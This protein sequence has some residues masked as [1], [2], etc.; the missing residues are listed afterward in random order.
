MLYG[1]ISDSSWWGDEVTPKQFA[2]DLANLGNKEQINVRINSGGG[3]V[4]AANAIATSLKMHGANVVIQIDGICASA[5]T[6]IAMAGNKIVIPSYAQMMIH[7]PKTMLFDYMEAKDMIKMADTLETIKE[8]IINA[9]AD[10]TGK[11]KKV[12]SKMMDNE[13]WMTGEEAIKE[14][15]ADELM[16]TETN[17]NAVLNGNI[18]IINSIQHDLSSFKNKPVLKNV[19]QASPPVNTGDDIYTNKNEEGAQ[20]MIKNAL[21]LK[22]QVPVVYDEV[23]K[24]GIEAERQRLKAFEVLNGKVDA[25]FLQEE[26]FKDSTTAESVLFKATMEGKTINAAYV[27]NAMNDAST[28]NRV[29]GDSS[30]NTAPD[31]VAGVLN[32]VTNIAKKTLGFDG[33]SR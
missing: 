4:F 32:R 29:N 21:E 1:S 12:L 27:A 6:I 23:F 9:Y 31:E 3:D 22:N 28:A 25:S 33:G 26:K 18:L 20:R 13:T 11:D 30:D 15:F 16:F 5:A 24:A 19:G 14:G 10:K 17:N 7:N 2:E 8:G